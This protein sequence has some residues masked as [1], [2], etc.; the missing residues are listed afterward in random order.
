MATSKASSPTTVKIEGTKP[1]EAEESDVEYNSMKIVE[2][3]KQEEKNS[4]K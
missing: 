3:L 2:T 1:E 4:L